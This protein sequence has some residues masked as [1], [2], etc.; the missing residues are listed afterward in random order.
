M[1]FLFMLCQAIYYLQ[2]AKNEIISVD[3]RPSDAINV[4]NRCKVY[5]FCILLMKIL[6]FLSCFDSLAQT[7]VC[8]IFFGGI[9]NQ[10]LS[11][12]CSL[13]YLFASIIYVNIQID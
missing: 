8:L 13:D 10:N 12:P 2:P 5:T 9:G 11:S 3:V 6:I 4:A 1:N 7:N